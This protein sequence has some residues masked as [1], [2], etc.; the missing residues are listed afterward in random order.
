LLNRDWECVALA[1][2]GHAFHCPH[3]DGG[4]IAKEAT[5]YDVL[6]IQVR[7]RL[8]SDEELAP[9]GVSTRVSHR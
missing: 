1:I 3:Y 4:G 5:E 8:A 2:G 7:A 6:A 9:I